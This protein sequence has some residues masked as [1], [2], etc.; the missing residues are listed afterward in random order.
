MFHCRG[1]QDFDEFECPHVR[2]VGFNILRDVEAPSPTGQTG[3]S[4]YIPINR[5]MGLAAKRS[6]APMPVRIISGSMYPPL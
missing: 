1:V 5:R 6:D 3:F 4:P 2:R